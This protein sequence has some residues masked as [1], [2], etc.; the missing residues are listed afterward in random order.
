MDFPGIAQLNNRTSSPSSFSDSNWSDSPSGGAPVGNVPSAGQVVL[1]VHVAST[2]ASPAPSA[3]DSI[4]SA[5]TPSSASSL[6]MSMVPEHMAQG[7]IL[8]PVSAAE[9]QLFKEKLIEIFPRLANGFNKDVQSGKPTNAA[10]HGIQAMFGAFADMYA[11]SVEK[12]N[13]S[14]TRRFEHLIRKAYTVI[15]RHAARFEPKVRAEKANN[16][17]GKFLQA[18][19]TF[20]AEDIAVMVKDLPATV[21]SN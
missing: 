9:L 4:H 7:Q 14:E 12:L 6:S 20:F 21:P 18:E 10:V 3:S 8:P 5:N 13:E 1:G 2:T 19:F 16:L 11:C 17:C 15:Q